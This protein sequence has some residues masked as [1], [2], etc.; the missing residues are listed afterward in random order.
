MLIHPNFDRVAFALGPL[1]VHWYGISY[2]IGFL[3]AWFLGRMRAKQPGSGWTEEQVSDLIFYCALGVVL[4]GR[5]GYTLFYN[6]GD[7]LANPLE[8]FKIWKGG[9]SFHGGFIGVMIAVA[10]F[11]R[12]AKKGYF[13]IADFTAPL[14]PLGLLS[15]R[16]LGN[17]VNAELY[18]RE[19][20]V[21][22]AMRFPDYE[23]GV[24]IWTNPR[25]PSQLYE[26]FLEGLVLFIILW[27]Y[28]R[29][30]R[31]AMMVSAL[32]LLGYGSFRFFVEFY[33]QPDQQ[34]GYLAFDWLTMGQLLCIPMFITGV[35]LII[36]A[37]RRSRLKT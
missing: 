13:E 16:L 25:H 8:I 34:L 10:L 27:F 3:L 18:G 15:V 11:R 9:M 7:S 24:L 17:F 2:V 5:V 31:P 32:F 23:T 19:S 6:F 35:V 37:Q 1:E 28:S 36:L 33:R 4:G 14:A 21:P 22:W 30:P 12:K 26:A 20:D 29:K